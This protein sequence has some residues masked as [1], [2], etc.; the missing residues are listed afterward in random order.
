MQYAPY[1]FMYL[2]KYKIY[3][4]AKASDEVDF[5]VEGLIDEIYVCEG[6]LAKEEYFFDFNTNFAK[7]SIY[8]ELIRKAGNFEKYW[9]FLQKPVT[10]TWKTFA[11]GVR[12][13]F[14]DDYYNDNVEQW[15][16]EFEA[17]LNE[18]LG[19]SFKIFPITNS[20]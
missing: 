14:K 20:L 4:V 13:Y 16:K 12:I 2:Y 19:Y 3:N 11:K 8:L 10:L 17:S 15:D 18:F 6:N 7:L 9:N 1:K 5:D